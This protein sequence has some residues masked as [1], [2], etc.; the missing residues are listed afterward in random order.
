M[1]FFINPFPRHILLTVSRIVSPHILRRR[2]MNSL[3]KSTNLITFTSNRPPQD[4]IFAFEACTFPVLVTTVKGLR[5]LLCLGLS[6]CSFRLLGR[7]GTSYIGL[8]LSLLGFGKGNFTLLVI[9]F[10]EDKSRLL[11]SH[12]GGCD[13]QS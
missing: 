2:Q 3:Q 9:M 4:D 10:I 7:F 11:V 5:F 12:S 13:G 8:G 1:S 6:I